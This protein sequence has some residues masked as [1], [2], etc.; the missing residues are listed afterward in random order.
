MNLKFCD[1]FSI[2]YYYLADTV[3]EKDLG[4]LYCT[5]CHVVRIFIIHNCQKKK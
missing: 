4:N 5:A 2:L 3:R 1:I